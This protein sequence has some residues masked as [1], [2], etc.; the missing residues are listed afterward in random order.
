MIASFLDPKLRE[1][2]RRVLIMSLFPPHLTHK[3][4]QQ[5]RAGVAMRVWNRRHIL[6]VR[7]RVSSSRVVFTESLVRITVISEVHWKLQRAKNHPLLSVIL[8]SPYKNPV[9]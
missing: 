6:Q 7:S 4:S 5:L 3:G 9:N 8:P 2:C 1:E